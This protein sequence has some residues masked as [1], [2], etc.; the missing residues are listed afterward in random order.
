M[1]MYPILPDI[2][3]SKS[4]C[5]P[6]AVACFFNDASILNK[7]ESKPKKHGHLFT[8]LRF[9]LHHETFEI[10]YASDYA[11][12]EDE[13]IE[14][15]YAEI[16]EY[17]VIP[18]FVAENNHVFLILFDAWEFYIFKYDLTNKTCSCMDVDAFLE[19]YSIVRLAVLVSPDDNQMLSVD[20][21]Q[22]PHL[23]KYIE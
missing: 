12:N 11:L 3:V 5:L 22:L 14:L 17:H 1:N 9:F 23:I 18:A 13:F 21:E 7:P 4:Q 15:V 19:T 10:V 16:P 8:D 20:I 6:A 2:D